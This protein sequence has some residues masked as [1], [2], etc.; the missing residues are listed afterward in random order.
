MSDFTS[1]FWPYYI[2][3]ITLV[4]IV[5]CAVFLQVPVD[6][7]GR[8]RGPGDHRPRLGRGP[9]GVEQPAAALVDLALLHHHRLRPRLSGAVSGAGRLRRRLGWTSSGQYEAE[10]ARV[11]AAYGPIFAKYAAH[12]RP[13]GRRRP[14]RDRDR[15][16]PVPATTAR[17]ATH[18]DARGSR[19][20]PNLADGDWLY[21]GDP[22]QIK[23][24]HP[25]RP[26]RHHAALRRG[27]GSPTAPRTWPT[28]C[29]RSRGCRMTRS[30]PRAARRSSSRP[31][32]PATA[33]TARATR[34][35]GAPNLTDKVWLYG[36]SEPDII[37][38]ITKGRNG[39]MPAHKDFLGEAKL[40]LLAAYVWSLS[41]P[42]A[43]ERPGK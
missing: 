41:H 40:H 5:A 23:E 13:A 14:G 3:I 1:E 12:G 37:E 18:R 30:A 2:A 20:F 17:N 32:L 19:G 9:G 38:T 43:T 25:E 35:L 28:T 39:L 33:R 36:G 42:E 6:P 11:D 8:G 27:A 16:E 15:A 7:A 10:R 4:S 34:Q 31:A 24:T 22:K 26:H 21:G 29:C